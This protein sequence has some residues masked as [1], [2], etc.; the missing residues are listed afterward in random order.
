VFWIETGFAVWDSRGV[1]L[2]KY[3]DKTKQFL[4][5]PRPRT[6]LS[7]E[8]QKMI[9]KRLKEY[10]RGFNQEDAAEERGVSKELGAQ[11]KRLVD[12]WDAWHALVRGRESTRLQ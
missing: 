4:W 2:E 7:K 9:R 8:R 1:E 12:E 3:I 11:R 5:R 10:S 6:L